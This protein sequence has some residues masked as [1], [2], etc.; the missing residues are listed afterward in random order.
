MYDMVCQTYITCE[1]GNFSSIL[2]LWCFTEI[3][4]VTF[5]ILQ[6]L[7]ILHLFRKC[8]KWKQLL[9]LFFIVNSFW[10]CWT[11]RS[12]P[13]VTP[14]YV[15]NIKCLPLISH[16]HSHSIITEEAQRRTHLILN[17]PYWAQNWQHGIIK[18]V[19]PSTTTLPHFCYLLN[20]QAKSQRCSQASKNY[21]CWIMS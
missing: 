7:P 8:E 9:C 15:L 21:C 1:L 4:A 16:H 19:S 20:V 5:G 17:M 18:L 3:D 12:E 11:L 6:V 2:K 14:C 13:F 10:G